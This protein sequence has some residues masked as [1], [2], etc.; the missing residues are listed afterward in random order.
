MKSIPCFLERLYHFTCGH[1]EKWWA[2]ADGQYKV[3]DT[4]YCPHCGK[5]QK[6]SSFEIGE[7]K[8]NNEETGEAKT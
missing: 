6:I 7:D 8:L 5:M 1:C 3:S 4:L 2:I